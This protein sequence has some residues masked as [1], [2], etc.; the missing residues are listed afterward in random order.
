MDSVFG[1]V[2]LPILVCVAGN[3]ISAITI[4]FIKNKKN[5]RLP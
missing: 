5:N 2:L 4:D 1:Y 3:I